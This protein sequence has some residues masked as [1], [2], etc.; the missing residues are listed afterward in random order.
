VIALLQHH[1][2]VLAVPL[3]GGVLA[4]WFTTQARTS[5][6]G[7]TLVAAGGLILLAALVAS[8]L[9]IVP[10]ESGLQLDTALVFVLTYLAGCGVGFLVRVVY[11]PRE[12]SDADRVP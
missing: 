3:L 7:W 1:L 11:L 12:A 8:A 2:P 6:A 4:G 10:G 9:K 5:R